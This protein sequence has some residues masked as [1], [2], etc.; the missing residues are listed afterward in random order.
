MYHWNKC[1]SYKWGETDNLKRSINFSIRYQYMWCFVTSNWVIFIPPCYNNISRL[2]L[3]QC[4]DCM[5]TKWQSQGCLPLWEL[6]VNVSITLSLLLV[7]NWCFCL[8][9]VFRFC[10]LNSYQRS[11]FYDLIDGLRHCMPRLCIGILLLYISG[12]NLYWKMEICMPV[13]YTLVSCKLQIYDIISKSR[14]MFCY[15][16]ILV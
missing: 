4:M 9:P 15:I 11:K 7:S 13:T 6:N 5:I 8:I 1:V 10:W 12:D 16:C 2:M 3:L 14:D